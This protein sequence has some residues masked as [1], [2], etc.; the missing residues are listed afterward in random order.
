[1]PIVPVGTSCQD[2]LFSPGQIACY[3]GSVEKKDN[4]EEDEKI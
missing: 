2:I 3:I 1:L 4:A